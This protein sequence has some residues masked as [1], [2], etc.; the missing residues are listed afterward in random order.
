MAQRLYVALDLETTGLDPQR[1]AIIEIGAVRFQGETVL[2]TYSTLV[3]P[4]RAIPPRIQQLTG[5][6]DADVVRAPTIDQVLPELLAFV[7]PEVAGVVAHNA[8]FDLGFLR[9]RGVQFQRPALDTH[10]LATILLPGQASYSLGELCRHFGIDLQDAHRALG[11]ALAAA[12][13]FQRLAERMPA[14]P[15]FVLHTIAEAAEE[16]DWP[17]RRLFADAAAQQRRPLAPFV[18]ELPI[19]DDEPPESLVCDKGAALLPL[20]GDRVDGC[21]ADGGSLGA[22]MG[23]LYERRAGQADMA[24]RVADA[25]SRGDHLMVEAGTG[26]GK[27]LAYLIP[28]A[29]WSVANHRRVVIA[30]NTIALQDQLLDKDI[31]QVQAVVEALGHVRPRAALLK[32]R[33]NYL[34]LRRLHQWRTSHRLTAAELSVLAR[35]LI[36]LPTTRTGDINEL[37][38]YGATDREVWQQICSDGATCADERCGLRGPAEQLDFYALAR[39][40]AE[41]AHLLVVN[42]ALLLAD[43]A[44]EGRVLPPYTHLIVDEAHHLEEAATDQLTYR[45]ELPWVRALLRRLAPS[46]EL[47]DAAIALAGRAGLPEVQRQAEAAASQAQRT[48]NRFRAFHEQLLAFALEHEETRDAGYVQRLPLDGR[49]RSQPMWSEVEIE[50]DNVAVDFRRLHGVLEAL[51]EALQA[52]RWAEREPHAMLLG[53]LMGAASKLAEL[54]RQSEQTIDAPNGIRRSGRVCWIEINEQRSQAAVAA[55]PLHVYD[56]IERELLHRRRCAVFTSATLRAG[57]TFRFLRERLGL[58]DVTAA[59]VESPFD[60]KSCTLVYLPSD[61]MQ[62]DHPSYQAGVERAIVDAAEACGG[63]TLALFTSNTHLRQTAEALRGPLERAGI[64]MLQ[65]GAS[66]RYRLLRDYR[67]AKH[68]VL[69]G[70][71]S[72]WEGIDLPGDE[73]RCLLIV[74][75]PFAV[76]NDPLVAARS[77]ESDNSFSDFMLPDAVLRFRQGFGRLIRRATDRGVVVLLDSRVWRREYGQVFLDALPPCTMRHAPLSILGSEVQRWL[78]P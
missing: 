67:A 25:F 55:A 16:S 3:N 56:V 52:A 75:L 28:A 18:P 66:S 64:A 27:T 46:G 45:L 73:L 63:H 22:L 58:W 62:P 9:T 7:G 59:V 26:T 17:L 76:P 65:Q 53:D 29:L 37:A 12:R 5:I 6:R 35:V 74:R 71:R 8:P 54:V 32:G 21:F 70:T 42:H 13:L 60:Y 57:A 43:I 20:D 36:W 68:A 40:N 33:A 39:R 4:R 51:V 77:Q 78:A 11:D 41:R 1:D 23:P 38:M 2:D 15:P 44:A 14:L 69:L 31:P 50:W 30:T 19:E 49:M 61:V 72:F 10:E 34:C 47:T 24:R 48:L